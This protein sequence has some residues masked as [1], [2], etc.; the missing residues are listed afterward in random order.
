MVRTLNFA[1]TPSFKRLLNLLNKR[2]GGLPCEDN[3]KK[4][5][6]V[7][8][9]QKMND[10]VQKMLT[11]PALFLDF[12]GWTKNSIFYFTLNV[13][14]IFE[15]KLMVANLKTF[16]FTEI[17]KTAKA[18]SQ[19]IID[20]LTQLGIWHLCAGCTADGAE[21]SIEKELGLLKLFNF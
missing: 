20:F 6:D 19:V 8:C 13:H 2:I 18:K 14:F 16:T 5:I 12:D 9:S 15:G 4:R 3:V 1:Q 21:T 11:A 10:I 7:K 17:H